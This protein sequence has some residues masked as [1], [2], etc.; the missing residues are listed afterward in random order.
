MRFGYFI[1]E[2]LIS[3]FTRLISFY[4][5]SQSFG[6]IMFILAFTFNE[7]NYTLIN[8]DSFFVVFVYLFS[9]SVLKDYYDCSFSFSDF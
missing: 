2:N 6:W 7:Y 5:L 3:V 1:N 8:G 4:Q 9:F